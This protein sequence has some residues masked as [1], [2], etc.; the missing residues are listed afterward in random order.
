[1]MGVMTNTHP[2]IVPVRRETNEERLSRRYGNGIIHTSDYQ[3]QHEG[4]PRR[5]LG[6]TD[7]GRE[8]METVGQKLARR[9]QPSYVELLDG[10]TVRVVSSSSRAGRI[11]CLGI[12]PGCG[13][14]IEWV[15]AEQ[16]KLDSPRA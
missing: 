5:L 3:G 4:P 16:V 10:R 6:T 9:S 14:A 2:P 15:D 13:G 1:M 7:P 8:I 12:D 11:T